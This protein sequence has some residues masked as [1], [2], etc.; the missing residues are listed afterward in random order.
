MV[1]PNLPL[2]SLKIAETN[3]RMI[4]SQSTADEREVLTERSGAFFVTVFLFLFV[5]NWLWN[6]VDMNNFCVKINLFYFK[7]SSDILIKLFSDWCIN[8]KKFNYFL[9]NLNHK[10]ITVSI[11]L[12]VN[13]FIDWLKKKK[14]CLIYH[15]NR[16][17]IQKSK[18]LLI[19]LYLYF[20]LLLCQNYFEN[21]LGT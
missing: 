8:W 21:I 19:I 18:N 7:F 11:N 16:G 20:F 14:K 1:S 12:V 13:L 4:H 2:M 9:K 15:M 3:I 6:K 5:F 10:L 17:L